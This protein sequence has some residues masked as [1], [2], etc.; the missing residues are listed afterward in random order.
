MAYEL[1]KINYDFMEE[2]TKIR[3]PFTGKVAYIALKEGENYTPMMQQALIRIISLNKMT[4]VTH[5]SDRDYAKAEKG[6][7]AEVRV[8]SVP[9]KVF[10]GKI[11]HLSPEAELVS[12]RFRCEVEIEDRENLLRHNQFA[13]VGLI[14]DY[15]ENSLVIPRI[16]LINQEYVYVVSNDKAER[17]EVK[18]GLINNDEV[19]IIGGL[20]EGE[21]VIIVGNIGLIDN[22]PVKII[23]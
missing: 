21:I 7:R 14:L 16:A 22:Y 11:T 19:E 17:R 13:R 12:G 20:N 6:S 5:L 9:E 15:A 1:A 8:D 18:T 2:N 4:I 3:A 10:K 23:N